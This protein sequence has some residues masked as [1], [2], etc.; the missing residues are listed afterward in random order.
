VS[1]DPATFAA[2]TAAAETA[3]A[4]TAA[5]ETEL[6]MSAPI[7]PDIRTTA[8]RGL[9]RPYN[10]GTECGTL[11]VAILIILASAVMNVRG[12]T[13]VGFGRLAALPEMCQFKNLFGTPC[14][15]CGLTRAFVSMGHLDVVSAWAY[16]PVGVFFY[17]VVVFQIP[18][19]ATQ[20]IRARRGLRQLDLGSAPQWIWAIL[21]GAGFIQW[22]TQFIL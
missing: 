20:I 13:Q 15:G 7:P 6:P 19:R 17:L 10:H 5:A 21:L 9:P 3:A 14:P 4:D 12:G 8:S 22:L 16:H 18:F 11:A 2:E 1:V